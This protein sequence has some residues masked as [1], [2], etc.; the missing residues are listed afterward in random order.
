[1][2][3]FK[4]NIS[5]ID[6]R[7]SVI[8]KEDEEIYNNSIKELKE[9]NVPYIETMGLALRFGDLNLR[10]IEEIAHRA[11]ALLGVAAFSEI[12]LADD[13]SND[14]ALEPLYYLEDVYSNNKYMTRKEVEY[15]K[16]MN[17]K[18][19]MQ[20]IWRYESCATLFWVLGLFDLPNVVDICDVVALTKLVQSYENFDDLIKSVKLRSVNE[21]FQMQDKTMRYRWACIEC[22]LKNKPLPNVDSSLMYERHY[23]LN[24]VLTTYFGDEWDKIN[25]P[26]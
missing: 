20:F 16:T 15:I 11:I 4:V 3:D 7:T 26:A 23:A 24:W 25:T 1:M 9:N 22:E 2:K 10:S 18:E 13:T 17:E 5:D 21:I 8:T 12:I 19:S 6:K 14:I